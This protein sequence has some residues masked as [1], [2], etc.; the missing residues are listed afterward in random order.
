MSAFDTSGFP[1]DYFCHAENA[2]GSV[3]RPV[4]VRIRNTPASVNINE[5]CRSQN[6]SSSCMVACGFYLDIDSVIDKPECIKDFDKLMKCAADGSDHRGCCANKD[7][8]RKCLNFCR[9]EPVQSHANAECALIHTK[10]IVGCFQENINKLPGPPKNL[11]IEKLSDDEIMVRWD[12]PVKNPN[13]IEGYRVFWHE[14]DVSSDNFSNVIQG[15]NTSKL[16]AKETK[17]RIGG[18]RHNIIYELVVKAG[19]HYGKFLQ[20]YENLGKPRSNFNFRCQRPFRATQIQHRR[21]NNIVVP[22]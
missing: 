16:D 6:V 22:N 15:S 11:K 5:C 13:T 17:I 10:T 14:A 3:T 7:V 4:S 21:P 2:L 18:L 20:N 9:G 19:N 12:P 8:P 1:G